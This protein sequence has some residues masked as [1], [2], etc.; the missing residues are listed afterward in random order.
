M[1]PTQVY[2]QNY[3]KAFCEV[4]KKVFEE[5]MPETDDKMSMDATSQ[6]V[7]EEMEELQLRVESGNKHLE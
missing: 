5:E 1:Q 2:L 3:D 7:L 6:F 4:F